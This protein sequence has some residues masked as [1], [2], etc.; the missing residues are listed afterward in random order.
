MQKWEYKV[1]VQ[2]RKKK[3]IGLDAMAPWEPE[4]DLNSLGANGWE[5]VSVTPLSDVWGDYASGT[6]TT[7]GWV[8]K[9]PIE[10]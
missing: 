2:T 5:L 9:R 8:F 6:T 7:L 3:G 1:V 10:P 4:L